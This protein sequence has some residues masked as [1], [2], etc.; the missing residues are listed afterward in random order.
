MS[1]EQLNTESIEEPSIAPDCAAEFLTPVLNINVEFQIYREN[2]L[3]EAD[4]IPNICLNIAE[5]G[6]IL[7]GSIIDQLKSKGYKLENAI[8]SYYSIQCESF[9]FCA[10][11]PIPSTLT[12]SMDEI[13]NQYLIIRAQIPIRIVPKIQTTEMEIDGKKRRTRIRRIGDVIDKVTQWRKYHQGYVTESGSEIK[14][15]LSEAAKYIGIPKKSLDDYYS[16]LRSGWE[17]GFDFNEHK[18]HNI[19]VLRAYIRNTNK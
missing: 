14:M 18:D 7:F 5:D 12:I 13:V 8:I 9:I 2:G 6:N 19:G 1:I 17:C 4:L 11:D 16:L 10:I 15:T 3:T